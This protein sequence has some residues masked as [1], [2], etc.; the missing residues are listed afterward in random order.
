MLAA[1]IGIVI[2]LIMVNGLL[3]LSELA[4]VSARRARLKT[5]ADQGSRGAGVAI[6]LAADPGRFLST[7]QI[8]ITLVGVLNGAFS[9][10]TLGE[11]FS[12]W[13]V[14]QGMAENYADPLAFGIVV[15]IITYVSLIIGEL[16]PK[17][18]ALRNPERFAAMVA[19]AMAVVSKVSSPL[20]WLLDLS[21]RGV[22]KLFGAPSASD[23]VVTQEEIKTIVAEA[24]SAGV[25]EASER[26][27]ITGV[28]RLG[29]RTVRA[30]MTPRRDVDVLDLAADPE[31]LVS[32][33]RASVHTRLPVVR[34]GGDEV[35]GVIVVKDLADA[36][37]AGEPFRPEAHV[38]PAPIIPDTL[39]AVAAIAMLK[40][41]PV[42]IG[43]V[44]DEYGHFEGVL[45]TADVLEAITGA[46]VT[47]EGPAVEQA[48]QRAD[49]SWLIAGAMP[50]DEMADLLGLRIP[51]DADYET[52]AG[53]VIAVMGRLPSVGDDVVAQ[54]HRFEVVD[55]DGRR[56]DKVLVEK[57]AAARRVS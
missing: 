8:G 19:P 28:L 16:V 7:V 40:A 26:D 43:L 35:L 24:Q 18:L 39:D 29:D 49:G 45:T 5:M 17:Q 50:A 11:R 33:I 48:V 27:M 4:V 54:G 6:R 57:V 32:A 41:S 9:G 15:V 36:A 1:E 56:I 34:G 22:L 37:L 30:M 46:F 25:L 53:F 47:Q 10:S 12:T 55:L 2:V 44:H 51:D 31:A 42:H 20:V 23:G 21:G 3:A 14:G 38:R 52:V 13:L